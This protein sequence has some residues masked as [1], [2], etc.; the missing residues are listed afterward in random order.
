M[1]NLEKTKSK[2]EKKIRAKAGKPRTIITSPDQLDALYSNKRKAKKVYLTGDTVSLSMTTQS[3]GVFLQPSRTVDGNFLTKTKALMH[4]GIPERVMETIKKG[5]MEKRTFLLVDNIIRWS[6][7]RFKKERS[8]NLYCVFLHE[9]SHLV[10]RYRYIDRKLHSIEQRIFPGSLNMQ[11]VINLL[12]DD[13]HHPAYIASQDD[14]SSAELPAGVTRIGDAPFRSETNRE[15]DFGKRKSYI[16]EYALPFSIVASAIFSFYAVEF[17]NKQQLEHLQ[18]NFQETIS[19]MEDS[20]YSGGR[21]ISLLER[22]QYFLEEGSQDRLV[23]SQLAQVI[24]IVSSLRKEEGYK[25]LTLDTI[26]LPQTEQDLGDWDIEF[27]IKVPES[28]EVS[29]SF[30]SSML[31]RAIA[32]KTGWE[33][34]TLQPPSAAEHNGMNMLLFYVGAKQGEAS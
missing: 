5:K 4:V 15:I 33:V 2:K 20:Y 6:L 27:T 13:L 8:F 14:L 30:Q 12:G 34:M 3:E 9:K 25:F 32:E 24:G 17:W 29:R 16:K 31:V 21:D 18:Q 7:Q 23:H 26:R 19:G 11:L 1:K 10:E 28:K 22:Q